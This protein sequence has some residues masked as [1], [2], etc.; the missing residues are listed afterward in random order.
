MKADMS[1]FH[2]IFSSFINLVGGVVQIMREA[3]AGGVAVM[4]IG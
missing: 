4:Q 3:A 2:V 1:E